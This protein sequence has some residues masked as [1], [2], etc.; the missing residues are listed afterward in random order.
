MNL[1]DRAI[2]AIQGGKQQSATNWQD[3]PKNT[4]TYVWQAPQPLTAKIKPE[5]YPID[6]LPESLQKA[7]QEV[8]AF[9]KAPFP[10]VV[11]SALTA[12]SLAIQGHVNAKRADKL[13]SPTS[14]FTLAIADSGERKTTLDGYFSKPIADYE[15]SEEEKAKPLVEKYKADYAAWKAQYDGLQAAIKN[16]TA[17]P[18]WKGDMVNVLIEQLQNLQ[19]NEPI[20]PLIPRIIL[21]DETP[22]NLAYSLAKRWPSSGIVSSEAGAVLG[23]HGMGKDS[24]MRNL[25][26]LNTLWDGKSLTIGRKTSES[27]TVRDARLT[28][29]LQIQEAT[30]RA[31]FDKSGA[32]ARGTGF[33]ARFLMCWPE[34][35]QGTRFYTEPPVSWPHLGEFNNRMNA[36]L[37]QPLPIKSE[38][39]LSLEPI[40]LELSK[41]AKKEWIAFHDAIEA[42]LSAN[43]ELY[44]IKDCASKIADNAVRIAAI[45]QVYGTQSF[46][47]QISAEHFEGASR[48]AAWHLSESRR[49]FGELALPVE[50]ANA[51]RVDGWL[52]NYC[53]FKNIKKI[54][55]RGIQQYCPVRKKDSLTAA[56]TE[57]A[58]LNRVR[59]IKEGK[60]IIVEINPALLEGGK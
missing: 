35:T 44:D 36:I 55:K 4:T 51:V 15:R 60:S 39:G 38:N 26:F 28:V 31:F 12:L 29:G 5:P 30:L 37:Y 22:E 52:L 43:G 1:D 53:R 46:A 17:N 59:L 21:Q 32:L 20:P 45:F 24:V 40:A 50:Q 10:M 2:T 19:A 56:L 8:Q 9:V 47:G 58:E 18:K 41:D 14:L 49:F 7:V 16:A 27:F 42:D 25:A 54:S 34:S 11:T 6:A 57:L 48:I 33:L 13:E 23:S 3:K